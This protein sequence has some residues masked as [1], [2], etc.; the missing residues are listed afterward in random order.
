M[1]RSRS[2]A[3]KI[4]APMA[5][6]L[7]VACVSEYDDE[8][9]SMP[10]DDY[11]ITE[12]KGDKTKQSDEDA[13][14]ECLGCEE[15]DGSGSTGGQKAAPD[16]EDDPPAGSCA[17]AACSEAD[18]LGTVMGDSG[19]DERSRQGSGS[20]WF[21]VDVVETSSSAIGYALKLKATL[22][23]PQG[24]NYDLF[25]HGDR[26]GGT[27]EGESTQPAGSTDS[28]LVS[29]GEGAIGNNK[30][31]TRR[32]FIEVRHVSGACGSGKW[33]LLVSGNTG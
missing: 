2:L 30:I 18:D 14:G 13:P 31:D 23:S 24:E 8:Q 5:A 19:A 1:N 3:S 20:A 12:G 17:E 6:L 28:A 32:M 33:T 21:A 10:Q 22:V 27:V 26:C 15:E 4:L 25:I 7:L 9:H 29:W 11:D 16:D